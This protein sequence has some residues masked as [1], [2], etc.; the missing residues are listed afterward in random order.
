MPDLS[1]LELPNSGY[2]TNIGLEQALRT[3]EWNIKIIDRISSVINSLEALEGPYVPDYITG[4]VPVALK[5]GTVTQAML[6]S[7]RMHVASCV[8]SNDSLT[9]GKDVLVSKVVIVTNC[10]V[11]FAQGVAL[12]DAIIATK[13]TGSKSLNSPSGLRLGKNDNCAEG[14]GAQLVTRGSAHMAG[15]LQMYGSQILA[16]HNI[17]FAAQANG[18]QGAAMVAG[19]RLTEPR[20]CRWGSAGKGWTTTSMRPISNL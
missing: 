14:G 19:A 16:A 1:Q 3:G 18:I 5:P 10:E 9:I 4:T 12:E 13:N 20:T 7:G 15:G 17:D 11:K 2:K 6:K 8:K